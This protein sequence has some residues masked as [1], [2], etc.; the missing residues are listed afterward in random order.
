[1]KGS[2]HYGADYPQLCKV[3]MLPE[4][5]KTYLILVLFRM[6]AI[7][8]TICYFTLYDNLNASL[9]NRFGRDIRL[10]M[11]SGALARG[12]NDKNRIKLKA[13]KIVWFSSGSFISKPVGNDADENAI[14]KDWLF[15][16]L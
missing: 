14:R 7:P 11:V 1:M 8:A 4:E 2:H 12:M 6:M 5:S 16:Y 10:S 3:S 15:G 13:S 9:Q